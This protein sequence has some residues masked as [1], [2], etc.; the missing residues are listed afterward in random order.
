MCHG[1]VS[2]QAY[3]LNFAVWK[4]ENGEVTARGR[5]RKKTEELDRYHILRKKTERG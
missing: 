3:D 2:P 1:P 5:R 4:E